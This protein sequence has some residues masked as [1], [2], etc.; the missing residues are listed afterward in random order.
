M[1]SSIL[2]TLLVAVF[3]SFAI[4][5]EK[6]RTLEIFA[7]PLSATKA[8]TLAQISY[9]STHASVKSYTAPRI[10]TGDDVVRV[11]FYHSS[12]SWSGVATA[13]S[14]FAPG[15]DKKVQLLVNANG[16][17]YHI[18]F[19]ASDLPSSSKT[20]NAKDGLGVEVVKTLP[21]PSPHLNKPIVLNA[22][23]KVDVTEPEKTFLQK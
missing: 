18:G 12:D 13:A 7:W 5:V 20:G 11:G 14:N 21:G 9:N 1:R 22:E 17:L 16:E 23:G 10:P 19:K 15:K 2:V 3:V 4:A 8:Q 6:E